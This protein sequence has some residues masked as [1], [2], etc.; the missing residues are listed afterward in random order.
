MGDESWDGAQASSCWLMCCHHGP[1]S[2]SPHGGPAPV[3]ILF[4]AFHAS[5]TDAEHSLGVLLC[6]SQA[7]V[8]MSL[9]RMGAF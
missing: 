6:F 1:T 9:A 5:A 4:V 3:S 8:G 7:H 2:V